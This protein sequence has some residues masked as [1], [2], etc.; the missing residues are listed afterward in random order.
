[1]VFKKEEKKIDFWN[2]Y[3]VAESKEGSWIRLRRRDP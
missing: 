2:L 1:M 3:G